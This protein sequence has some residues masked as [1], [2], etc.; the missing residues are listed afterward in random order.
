[1]CERSCWA[2]THIVGVLGNFAFCGQHKSTQVWIN[3]PMSASLNIQSQ[4]K[5]ISMSGSPDDSDGSSPNRSGI[6]DSTLDSQSKAAIL[7]LLDVVGRLRTANLPLF[8]LLLLVDLCLV[9]FS[10]ML[11]FSVLKTYSWSVARY[12]RILGET[13]R[14]TIPEI[15]HPSSRAVV[16]GP[17]AEVLNRILSS[18][19]I[20]S[21]NRGVIFQTT[22]GRHPKISTSN[23]IRGESPPAPVVPSF[24]LDDK[25]V[26][27]CWMVRSLPATTMSRDV[28]FGSTK[29]RFWDGIARENKRKD[30]DTSISSIQLPDFRPSASTFLGMLNFF[31]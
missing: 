29:P 24:R 2:M 22:A 6:V 26:G 25:I 8:F 1:M 19:A 7:I 17:M 27:D 13:A 30:S 3:G 4:A 16:S 15:P 9:V 12:V 28:A 5:T 23:S 21:A 31:T 10:A 18:D 14:P 20:Q 11:S